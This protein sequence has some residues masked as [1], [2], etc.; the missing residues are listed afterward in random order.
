MLTLDARYVSYDESIDADIYEAIWA[1]Q[2]RGLSVQVVA[3]YILTTK[4]GSIHAKMISAAKRVYAKRVKHFELE[5]KKLETEK[6]KKEN[7]LKSFI[8]NIEAKE[9]LYS[10]ITV[11]VQDSLRAGN[12]EAGTSN[13]VEK[14]FSGQV[15]TK[16]KKLFEIIKKIASDDFRRAKRIF[17]AIESAIKRSEILI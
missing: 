7:L 10:D 2:S 6:I 9:T 13:F 11:T 3:G 4:L 8:T 14:Y 15:Q 1:Q 5:Q 16:A 17:A 12:C